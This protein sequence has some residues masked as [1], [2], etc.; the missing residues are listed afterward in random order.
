MHARFVLQWLAGELDALPLWNGG[1]GSPHITDG[2]PL[3]RS[4]TEISGVHS[5]AML[6]EWR[7]PWPDDPTAS[8]PAVAHGFAC[9]TSQ[10]LTW[11]CG[12]AATGPLT[13]EETLRPPSLYQVALEVCRA[14]AGLE[15][16]RRTQAPVLAGRMAGVMETFTW[17]AGWSLEPPV[18]RHG[19]LPSEDCAE[20]RE[21]CG[22]DN[23][24]ACLGA[25]CTACCRS[26]CV[27]GFTQ[28]TDQG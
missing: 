2:A 14:T 15:H 8:E 19:H 12:A 1:V 20:R 5:W 11:T 28:M 7:N 4:Q 10:L 21:L 23:E 24:G 16:A 27:H 13:G 3:A 18:D 22:C 17:L 6:A 25:I 9:G 26:R